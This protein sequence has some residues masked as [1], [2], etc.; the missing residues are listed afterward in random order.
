MY[1]SVTRRRLTLEAYADGM[2][3][4]WAKSTLSTGGRGTVSDHAQLGATN[5][6]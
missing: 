4:W 2:L 3:P 5:S 6:P 1:T